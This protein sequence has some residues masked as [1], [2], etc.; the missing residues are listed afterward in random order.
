MG[1]VDPQLLKVQMCIRERFV[2]RGFVASLRNS[3]WPG[4]GEATGSTWIRALLLLWWTPLS[5]R[6][7]V[8]WRVSSLSALHPACSSSC[9]QGQVPLSKKT[10]PGRVTASSTA[11]AAVSGNHYCLQE[12]HTQNT[13]TSIRGLAR[14]LV[15]VCVTSGPSH[16]SSLSCTLSRT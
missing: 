5:R 3:A 6:A 14:I 2:R 7:T 10:E 4:E 9:S 15:L 11:S 16:G 8:R 12:N 13:H 1:I